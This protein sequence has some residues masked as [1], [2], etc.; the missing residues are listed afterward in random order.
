[1]YLYSFSWKNLASSLTVALLT[2][3]LLVTS[4][5]VQAEDIG[6]ETNPGQ[7]NF[8]KAVRDLGVAFSYVP[9]E[10]AESQGILGFNVGLELS[11]PELNQN[12]YMDAL[13]KNTDAPSN[14]VLPK[15]HVSKGLPMGIDVSG[16][17]SGDPDGNA[18]L[19]GA[20]VKYPILEGGMVT[21]AV[22]LRGHGTQLTGVDDLGLRTYGGDISISKGF[23]LPLVLGVT[24]FAGYSHFQIKGTNDS[25]FSLDD[26]STTEG[27]FF[28]GSRISVGF[29]NLVGEADFGEVN[30]YSLR[31]NFG[32]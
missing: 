9:T 17:A 28:V 15:V 16:F 23:D 30:V 12:P 26:H 5:P 29:L 20:A 6:F 14:L 21:P 25:S 19:F 27:K 11:V 1:L 32:F 10:P 24:P 4:G 8:D 13:F 3:S 18:R 22:A 31:A 2:L 7:E